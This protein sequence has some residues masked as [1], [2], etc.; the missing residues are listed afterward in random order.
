MSNGTVFSIKKRYD[1]IKKILDE[2]TRR[3]WAA[4]EAMVMG[5]GGVIAVAKATGFAESTIRIGKR[6]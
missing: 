1:L 4:S 2:K 5:H 6:E 3:L